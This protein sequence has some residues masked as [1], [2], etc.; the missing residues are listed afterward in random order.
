MFLSKLMRECAMSTDVNLP[1]VDAAR[2]SNPGVPVLFWIGG[3][4]VRT[5][6]LIIVTVITTRVASPQVENLRSV[7]ETPSDLLR[8]GLGLTVCLWLIANVFILP[9]D[10]DAY[11]TWLYLGPAILPLSLL[12]AFVAW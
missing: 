8:V 6:F 7:L 10:T 11:R 5:I 2:K 9:K 4:A 1:A 3:V 12:C